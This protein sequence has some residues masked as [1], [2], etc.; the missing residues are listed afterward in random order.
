MLV[1]VAA[2]LLAQ[3]PA[4]A[5]PPAGPA[6]PSGTDVTLPGLVDVGAKLP[7][8]V[9]LKYATDDNFMHRDVYGGLKRCFLVEDA[10]RMLADA[11]ALLQRR[12]PGLTFVMYDCARPRRVQLVMWDVVKGTKQQGYVANPHAPPGSVHNTG[13]AVDMSLWDTAKNAPLDMG[14]PFDF[15]GPAAQPRNEVDL[16]KAGSLSSEQLANRLLLREVMLR[17]GFRILPHEWWHFDCAPGG[18][19]RRKYPTIE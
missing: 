4:E 1:V 9:E 3:A 18:E 10:A 14:T 12:A 11:H 2:L 17:A 7:V 6:F 5:A 19:A 16:W 8:H 13:C 15:F